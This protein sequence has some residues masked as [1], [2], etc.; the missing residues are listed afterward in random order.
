MRTF[1]LTLIAVTMLTAASLALPCDEQQSST[2]AVQSMT[3]AELE[4]AGDSC[5]AQKDYEQATAYFTEALRKD[6]K[7]AK[8]YNKRGLA[9]LSNSQ[10]AAA[11]ADFSKA[12]KY[13]RNYPEAW[14]D[15]GVV[16]Y[17]DRNYP[18][19]VKY[20]SKAIA[21]DEL[22][23]NFH[24]NLGLTY[25][26]QDQMDLAMRQ[27]SRA[28]QLDPDALLHS[29]NAGMSAQ[30]TDREQRAKQDFMMARV[31]AKLGQVDNCLVCLEKA[32]DNGYS[33]LT[34]VYKEDDFSSVRKDARLASI[35]PPPTPPK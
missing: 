19:A 17:I 11:R 14:N 12:T 26:A 34:D 23:P 15:L 5:R 20:F 27:Y 2:T 22:R 28:V 18:A 3:V 35:V 21:L 6:K 1:V 29:S 9:E 8:L 32:K 16:S 33:A 7:N 24:V 4:K 31:Y 10:F 25:F 13:N 30:I